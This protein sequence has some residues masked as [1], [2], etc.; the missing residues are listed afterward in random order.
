VSGGPKVGVNESGSG[1]SGEIQSETEAPIERPS[2]VPE[3]PKDSGERDR[4]DTLVG[5]GGVKGGDSKNPRHVGRSP[6]E[7][8]ER[9]RKLV[10]TRN[11]SDGRTVTGESSKLL[12]DQGDD[13]NTLNFLAMHHYKN[14]KYHLAKLILGRAIKANPKLASLYSNLGIILLAEGEERD[15]IEYLQKAL[16]LD[17]DN[18]AANATLGSYYVKYSGFKKAV[19][20]LA[21]AYSQD[22]DDRDVANNYAVALASVGRTKEARDIYEQILRKGSSSNNVKA[23]FNYAVLLIDQMGKYEEGLKL[24]Y[25]V[26]FIG[27]EKQM[28]AELN[29]LEKKAK[30]AL[31]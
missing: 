19:V 9:Y 18:W 22:P 31:K 30:E 4:L 7:V 17:S 2:Q 14:G 6:E 1:L 23:L 28:V 27:P 26:N 12:A 16:E 3:P 29:S 24:V 11:D 15:G 21:K 8:P 20:P 25:K 5:K 10:A 13:I